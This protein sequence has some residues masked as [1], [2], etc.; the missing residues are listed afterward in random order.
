MEVTTFQN[1]GGQELHTH[2]QFTSQALCSYFMTFLSK[3]RLKTAKSTAE[4]YSEESD[5][6]ILLSDRQP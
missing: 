6:Y 4:A 2:S 3:S 1:E 5:S